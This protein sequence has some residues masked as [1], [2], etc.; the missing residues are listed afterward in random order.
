M[1]AASP[2]PIRA[3]LVDDEQPARQHL[4]ERLAAHPGIEIVGEADRLESA[5]A[6]IESEK[7]DVVFLDV[8]MPG[9]TGFDL[10][11][12]LGDL[13]SPPAVVFVTAYDKYAVKAFEVNALDYLTK[14]VSPRR[15]ALTVERLEKQ[16][17]AESPPARDAPQEGAQAQALEMRDFIMLRNKKTMRMVETI[18]IC[19]VGAEADYTR[20]DLA[21]GHTMLVRKSMTQWEQE[22]PS[23]PFLKISRRLLLNMP[24]IKTV[25]AS[26]RQSAEIHLEGMEKPLPVSRVELRRIRQIGG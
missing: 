11:P 5:A 13:E 24:R 7:P 17:R 6:L 10:L 26:D 23:P 15:L 8:Q 9:Q 20:I 3:V 14:P 2:P 22:L 16:R 21:G 25:V 1:N 19:A 12:L 4:R 18:E